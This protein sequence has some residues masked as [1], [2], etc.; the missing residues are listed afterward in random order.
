MPPRS[1]DGTDV[2]PACSCDRRVRRIAATADAY[3]PSH[4]CA[5]KYCLHHLAQRCKRCR[6]DHPDSPCAQRASSHA[7]RSCAAGFDR[8]RTPAAS[9]GRPPEIRDST[10]TRPSAHRPARCGT[11]RR[12]TSSTPG[13]SGCARPP[14][15]RAGSVAVRVRCTCTVTETMDSRVHVDLVLGLVGPVRLDRP[16][17][18]DLAR[19]L[20]RFPLLADASWSSATVCER[21]RSARVAPPRTPMKL[22]RTPRRF[23]VSRRSCASPRSLPASPRFLT[24]WLHRA[25][26]SARRSNTVVPRASPRRSAAPCAT[27]SSGPARP[28]SPRLQK[29]PRLS[30]SH[31][32]RSPARNPSK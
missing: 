1:A 23:A 17:L 22:R 13:P 24:V 10:P 21:A 28:P 4:T 25:P 26:R 16:S 11:C 9:A 3:R 15:Q 19:V 27:T 2:A 12:T 32:P 29:R 31:P 18:R 8:R 30:E 7:T 20:Q 5:R 6:E 14:R